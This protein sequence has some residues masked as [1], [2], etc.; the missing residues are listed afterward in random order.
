MEINALQ[1]KPLSLTIP[2]EFLKFLFLFLTLDFIKRTKKL[3]GVGIMWILLCDELKCTSIKQ[4]M[5]TD[6][7][8][9]FSSG[10]TALEPSVTVAE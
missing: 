2:R 8:L 5:K 10:R 6:F 1:D 3:T 4:V 9:P 7:S